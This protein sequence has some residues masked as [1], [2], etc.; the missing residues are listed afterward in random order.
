MKR[1]VNF[2]K[3]DHLEFKH[4]GIKWE[5]RIADEGDKVLFDRVF[6]MPDDAAKF[7]RVFM[8]ELLWQAGKIDVTMPLWG[9]GANGPYIKNY[10]FSTKEVRTQ[11]DFIKSMK[12]II[13]SII[14]TYSF[15]GDS[16]GLGYTPLE[17]LVQSDTDS[18]KSHTVEYKAG[19]W[20]CSCKAFV[21]SKQ[22]PPDCK[23]IQK[24]NK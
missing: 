21:Y 3:V 23:H 7:G 20:T 16:I 19:L 10:Q 11:E 18:S 1:P 4:L 2:E 22:S 9:E 8:I 5:I 17:F 6:L 24:I 15:E 12:M 13:S 14:D